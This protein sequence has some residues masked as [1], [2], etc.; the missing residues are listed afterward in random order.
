MNLMKRLHWKITLREAAWLIG[1][2]LAFACGA[3]FLRPDAMPGKMAPNDSL[4][5]AVTFE[6]AV[7]HFNNG[8]AIFADTRAPEAFE[9]GHIKGALNLDPVEFDQWSHRLFLYD[10]AESTLITYCEDPRC[11]ES[12]ELAEKLTWL[13]FE[14]VYYLKE[15]WQAWDERGLPT[16]KG[17]P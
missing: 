1:L 6:D 9:A 11:P 4:A 7:D 3:Y 15:G 13:G 10:A 17:G 14:N 5:S 8:T 16:E 2:S 12:L